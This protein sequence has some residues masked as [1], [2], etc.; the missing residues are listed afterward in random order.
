MDTM[1]IE[2]TSQKAI[3]LLHE[4]EGLNLIKILHGNVGPVKTKLSN[5]YKGFMTR[6]EGQKLN[7]HIS[8]MRNEWN[9]I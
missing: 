3:R 7:E 1:L 6:E 5:K 8:Q 2:L 4:L 9:N